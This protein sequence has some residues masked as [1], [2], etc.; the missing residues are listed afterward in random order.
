MKLHTLLPGTPSP[1][2]IGVILENI[3]KNNNLSFID[4]HFLQ[5]IGTAIGTKVAPPYANL[6]TGCDKETIR[7]PLSGQ[8]K[9]KKKQKKTDDTILQKEPNSLTA[10]LL[11]RK[12]PLEIITCNISKALLHSCDTLFY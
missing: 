3:L 11:T 1:Y 10:S 6:F 4:R 5:L 7:K 9:T 8:S 12:Y 2:T